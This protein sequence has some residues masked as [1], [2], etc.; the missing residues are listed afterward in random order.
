MLTGVLELDDVAMADCRVLLISSDMTRLLGS[1][2]TD[3]NGV[4]SF[5]LPEPAQ[6]RVIVLAKIQTPVLSVSYRIIELAIHGSGPHRISIESTTE[7]FHLVKAHIIS[8]EGRPPFLLAHLDPLHLVGIPEPLEKFFRTVDENVVD[9]WF[10]QLRV[11][12][13]S[14]EIRVQNGT[15]RI[16]AHYF[17][18][19]ESQVENITNYGL[20]EVT[21]DGEETIHFTTPFE[22]FTLNIDRD[23]EIEMTIG[24][25]EVDN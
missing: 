4:F 10:S 16:E 1:T 2:T 3:D 22:S 8:Y 21:S 25:I 7:L 17:N 20:K 19:R 11:E 15:Y 13:D 18:K 5:V 14:L 23:R 6:S 9:S 12:G 24:A